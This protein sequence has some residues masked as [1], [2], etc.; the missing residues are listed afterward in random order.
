MAEALYVHIPFC[1]SLCAYCDF[2]KVLYRQEWAESYLSALFAELDA[3]AIKKVR[4]IYVGGGTPSAL[5][6]PLLAKLLKK[7]SPLLLENGEFTFEANP[8]S[9]SEE[10]IALLASSKVNRVS[11]GVESS[12]EKYLSLMGRKH[13]FLKAKEAVA[14]LKKH[15]ISNINAD[16]IYALPGESVEEI[17]REAEAFLSLGLPHLSAYT[18]ILEDSS[19]F[20]VE[21]VKEAGEDEQGEQYEKVLSLL[22]QAGYERYEVSNFALP[23]FASRHNLTY[24]HDEEYYGVGLGASGYLDGVRYQNTRSL[25]LY[26][27]GLGLRE[28]E[29]RSGEEEFL[30]CNLRLA[31]G[32]PLASFKKRFGKDFTLAYA[33]SLGKMKKEGLLKEKEGRIV[34]TDRGIECLDYV[35]VN[36]FPEV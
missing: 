29:E 14:C 30:L 28:K 16:W 12:L 15:G 7:L 10:K 25:S 23:G 4:T 24:W 18:L 11:L 36:L 22:R 2:P 13:T 27:K 3:Y 32:F 35:L 17:E 9:L 34:P 1:Q 6:L 26:M 21:G 31:E 19:L 20:R 8:E 33:P 5:P